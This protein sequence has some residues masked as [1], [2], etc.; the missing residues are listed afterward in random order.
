[1]AC[2]WVVTRA[3]SCGDGGA[4]VLPLREG[5][6][7]GS[8]AGCECV[9]SAATRRPGDDLGGPAQCAEQADGDRRGPAARPVRATADSAPLALVGDRGQIH[10]QFCQEGIRRIITV[11]SAL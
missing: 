3:C 4:F 11:H 8:S 1:V 7:L 2:S 10:A 9:Q 5:P 6:G